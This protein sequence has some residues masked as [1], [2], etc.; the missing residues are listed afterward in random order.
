MTPLRGDWIVT[1]AR[2]DSLVS[3]IVG[4]GIQAYQ[5]LEG[6]SSWRAKHSVLYIGRLDKEFVSRGTSHGLL[7]HEARRKC[8]SMERYADYLNTHSD[9][10]L[11]MT[12]PCGRWE[13]WAHIQTQRHAVYQPR[14]VPVDRRQEFNVALHSAAWRY[15]SRRY[16]KGQL[17]DIAR[18]A[19]ERV[20]PRWYNRLFDASPWR[21]VCSG[22][23]AE[24]TR[25]ALTQAG[26]P[27]MA[28]DLY[29]G[30]AD[31]RVPPA[32]PSRRVP[33]MNKS[34]LVMPWYERTGG[35][36]LTL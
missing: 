36:D 8:W 31:E 13:R 5:R 1:N 27:K 3:W 4:A 32:E 21:T 25:R 17:I 20:G 33:P 22:A 10:C 23:C 2:P 30:L 6:Y 14:F 19:A 26:C 18:N 12:T 35:N 24:S 15:I 7:I 34:R 28:A 9:W 11:S 16:D 29:S